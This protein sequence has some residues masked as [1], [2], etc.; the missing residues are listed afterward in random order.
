MVQGDITEKKTTNKQ[1]KALRLQFTDWIY[2][3]YEIS[4]LPK[5]FFINLDKVYKGTYKNLK[6]PVPLED[7]WD[8]WQ[9][10]MPYLRK[11]YDKNKRMGK[12]IEGMSRVNYDMSIVLSRY[13]SYLEWKEQQ[14]QALAAEQISKGSSIDYSKIN[15]NAPSD[16]NT[17]INDILDEI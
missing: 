2:R 17:D 14:K 10:K 7:L 11:V 5:H 15:T 9:K 6:K 4:F 16:N 13:D 3:E 1:E 12:N 8:M